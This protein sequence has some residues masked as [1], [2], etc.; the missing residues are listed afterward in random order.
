MVPLTSLWLPILLSAVVVFV[1]SSLLHMVLT[2]H[3]S[4]YKKLPN[5]EKLLDAIRNENP[6]RGAYFF[7]YCSHKE[8]GSPETVEK[9]KKGPVGL[10]TVLPS[11]PPSMGKSLTQW[12]LFCVVMGI[13]VAYLTGRVLQA[14]AA[15]L[16]VFRVAGT[17]AFVGY[18][19]SQVTD[20]IWRGQAWSATIKHMFDGLLYSL[21]TAGVFGWLWPR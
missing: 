13:F 2:Y 1:L 12:F 7:P 5:E 20:S 6:V 8:M 3:R 10:M 9:F 15:Y 14:G 19:A 17:V 11:G 21:F 16:A 18:S 4:D